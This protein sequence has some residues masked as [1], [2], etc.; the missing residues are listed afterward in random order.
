MTFKKSIAAAAAAT[1]LMTGAMTFPTSLGSQNTAIT[2]EAAS[3]DTEAFVTRM[4]S[5][6]LG[7]NPDSAGL[8]NWV[9]K[10]NSHK[11]NA[12]DII[13]G[14]FFSDEYK[15][16]NKSIDEQITDCYNA[17]LGRNPD[18]AGMQNWKKRLES[19]MTL[20]TVCAGFAGSSE[21]K[22]LCASYGISPGNVT[23]TYSRDK[24]FERTN[25]VY[26]LYK[27]CLGRNPDIA[28]LENWCKSIEKG[29]TGA[30]IAEGFIFSSE[31][32]KR[33]V[34]NDDFVLMLYNTILGRNPDP[35]GLQ[36]WTD[37][38][39]YTNTRQNVTNGFLFSSEFK[40]Q[41]SK[42]GIN[43]GSKLSE[44]DNT[45]DWK[46]NIQFL[47][48]IN[49]LRG[50]YGYEPLVT[51]QDLWEDVAMVRAS[52]LS[53][54]FAVTRPNGEDYTSLY[55]DMVD[56]FAN[57]GYYDPFVAESILR[58]TYIS[59]A[60]ND[61]NDSSANYMDP[62][63]DIAYIGHY[64]VKDNYYGSEIDGLVHYFAVEAIG[65]E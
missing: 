10:L 65:L 31:Y 26:R 43:V 6:V 46:Y 19:G 59:E 48:E 40:G 32:K 4:Y 23:L 13:V 36:T 27:N 47:N 15:S 52:E 2:A 34:S 54:R 53:S 39:N 55:E 12:S 38:L 64:A 49:H 21:F 45:S 33:Y 20:R 18:S 8:K 30:K 29:Q 16:R 37:K 42:A 51:R 41:C 44:K 56:P 63:L 28:G 22:N 11:A 17:M 3:S 60:L 5:V 1:M 57:Q 61:L 58:Y 9:N 62:D 35:A 7:R 25:F 50:I 14:F 24:N